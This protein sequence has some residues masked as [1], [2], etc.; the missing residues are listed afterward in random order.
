MKRRFKKFINPSGVEWWN[1]LSLDEKVRYK[2][3]F[4]YYRQTPES[5]AYPDIYDLTGHRI[6][7]LSDKHIT[8]IWVFRDRI[9][10]FL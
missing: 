6:S 5:Q 10:K 3:A 1:G 7:Q 9:S 2:R 8:R 4:E